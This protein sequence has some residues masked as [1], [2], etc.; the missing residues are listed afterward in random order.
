MAEGESINDEIKEQ[1][2][3][4]KNA[5]FKEK[6][7]YF[8]YYYKWHVIIT[9]IILWGII[10]FVSDLM[11]KKETVFCCAVLNPQYVIT[12]QPAISNE[13]SEYFGINPKKEQVIFDTNF[14]LREDNPLL[15]EDAYY[16]TLKLNSMIMAQEIDAISCDS[17]YVDANTADGTFDSLKEVL[18]DDLFQKLEEK[19]LIYYT[20]DYQGQTIPAAVK[21]SGN[22]SFFNSGFYKPEEEIYVAFVANSKYKENFRAF[23]QYL[24][25]QM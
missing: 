24:Y 20:K 1:Q 22:N 4:L 14:I 13:L 8:I 11:Q 15:K 12:E 2:A 19:N 18:D 16:A 10:A 9:L 25:N 7:S 17:N 23:I 6:L 5:S 3:K 21:V